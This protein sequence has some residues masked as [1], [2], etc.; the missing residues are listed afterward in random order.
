MKNKI[1]AYMD[2]ATMFRLRVVAKNGEK[3]LQS[4][5]VDNHRKI[6]TKIELLKT[7]QFEGHISKSKNNQFYFIITHEEN[8][9]GWSETYTTKSNAKRGLES[10]KRILKDVEI[11][12][13][14]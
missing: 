4:P 1:E 14:Y 10:L 3:V 9:L 7:G 6:A 12:F 5:R 2:F 11:V 13:K 8:T